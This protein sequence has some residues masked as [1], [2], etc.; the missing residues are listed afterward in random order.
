MSNAQEKGVS[1]YAALMGK[2]FVEMS[3]V[4]KPE[5]LATVVFHSASSSVWRALSAAYGSAGF[6][7]RATSVLDKL[8]A[9]FKQVVST[10]S[11]KG[12]PVILLGKGSPASVTETRTDEE[13]MAEIFL[14]ADGSNPSEARTQRL[15]SSSL[16]GV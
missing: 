6:R 13:V 2:V 5:G 14:H 4:L 7:V 8:Q 12:D 9:S 1:E 3:R 16:H 15:Y 11:V 10:V